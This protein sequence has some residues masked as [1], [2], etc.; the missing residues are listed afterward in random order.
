MAGI[1]IDLNNSVLNTFARCLINNL[2]DLSSGQLEALKKLI[3]AQL[4]ILDG[5]IASLIAQALQYDI[6][7][8]QYRLAEAAIRAQIQEIEDQINNIPRGDLDTRCLEIALL[9]GTLQAVFAR[10]RA[11]LETIL[12]ELERI[13]SFQDELERARLQYERA[14]EL[15]LS[16]LDILDQLILEAKC[17]EA[18]NAPQ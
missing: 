8:Q 5:L 11:P 1:C 16:L 15:F 7:A 6:L 14:K 10:L 13:L 17:I 2:L 18:A 9:G 3:Q 4:L 12:D